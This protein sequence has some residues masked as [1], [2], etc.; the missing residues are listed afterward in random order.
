MHSIVFAAIVIIGVNPVARAETAILECTAD[1]SG[2]GKPASGKAPALQTPGVLFLSFRTWNIPKWRI[3]SA[4]LFLHILQGGPPPKV[5]IAI[6][7]E[8]W[9]EAASSAIAT[10]SLIFT[11]HAVNF[12]PQEWISIKVNARLMDEIAAGRAHG[13]AI[14]FSG[15]KPLVIHARESGGFAPYMIVSGRAS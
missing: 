13:L 5:R 8:P 7:T 14:R 9:T 12:Q 4:D 3:A 10:G 6:L 2:P 1:A 11:A 15:P